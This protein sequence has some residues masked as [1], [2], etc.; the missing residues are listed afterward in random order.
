LWSSPS[1]K[2]DD[3]SPRGLPRRNSVVLDRPFC[4]R[5]P[6]ASHLTYFRKPRRRERRGFC[7]SR[8]FRDLTIPT[9]LSS[10]FSRDQPALA[11]LQDPRRLADFVEVIES[12]T[13]K[14][15]RFA[16]LGD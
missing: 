13:A 10:S 1:S 12:R 15:V 5:S 3:G 9:P 8:S 16:E 14:I 2:I 7:L 6:S 4:Y 11:D